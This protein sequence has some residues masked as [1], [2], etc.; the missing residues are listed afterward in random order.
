M[1]VV[2]IFVLGSDPRSIGEVNNAWLGAMFVWDD[3]AKRYCKLRSFF[4]ATKEEYNLIWNS[5]KNQEMPE[6]ERIVLLSTMDNAIVWGKDVPILISAFEQY[7]KERI[8]SNYT[9]QA[10]IIKNASLLLDDALAWQQ[11]STGEFWGCQWNE[12]IEENE[13]YDPRLGTK[14][15]DVIQEAKLI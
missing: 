7:S 12:N 9:E 1:S 8:G 4:Q 13:Y 14:H 15:F 2:E 10:N 3:I 6:W 5:W 11:T